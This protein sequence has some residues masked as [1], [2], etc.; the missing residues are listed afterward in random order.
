MKRALPRGRALAAALTAALAGVALAALAAG[1][2]S[3]NRPLNPL[4]VPLESR[5]RNHTRATVAADVAPPGS[6]SPDR[7]RP[8]PDEPPPEAA[9]DDNALRPADADGY[10]VGLAI[11]GGGSR[12]ANFAAACMFHLQRLG[13]L[14][15]VD[16][17]SSVSGGSLTAAY[18]CSRPDGDGPDDWNP[19]AAQRKLTHSFAGDVLGRTL[20]PWN[21]LALSLTNWDRTDLLAGS[22]RDVLFRTGRPEGRREM[23]F[24]DLRPDRPRLIINATDLQSG[25]PFLFTDETFDNLNSDLSRYPLSYAVAAS[26]AVP[27]LMHHVTVRDFSTRFRQFRHLVDGGVTDNLGVQALAQTYSAHVDAARSAGRDDP[28]PNG[29]VLILLDATTLYDIRIGER[30]D[31][32]LLQNLL[33]GASLSSTLLL[34]RVSSATLSDL[35]VR[36]AADTETAAQLRER[37]REL[38]KTGRLALEDRHGHAVQVFHVA[39]SRADDLEEPPF[40]SFGQTVNNIATY[41]NIDDAEAFHLYKA[42]ELVIGEKFERPLGDLAGEMGVSPP[43]PG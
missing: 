43:P 31:I 15:R 30:G 20:L 16:Y 4:N 25:R 35:I 39:L 7:V 19:G 5:A 12:S 41:F 11:S 21:F 3:V 33:T 9:G 27:V 34:N 2:T 14:Q 23:T 8:D 40:R 36:N 22:F 10:F 28:Y 24:A 13:L 29:V 17:I 6:R 1:C 42:A 37:I 18:Y 26:A 32:G 38:E